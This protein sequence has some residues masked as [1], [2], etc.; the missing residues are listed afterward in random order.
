M[1]ITLIWITFRY[2]VS[3]DLMEKEDYEGGYI[4]NKGLGFGKKRF[5]IIPLIILALIIWFN[6]YLEYIIVTQI[7]FPI[8]YVLWLFLGTYIDAIDRWTVIFFFDDHVGYTHSTEISNEGA[9]LS[10]KNIMKYYRAFYE[11]IMKEK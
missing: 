5:F 2:L 3:Y 6:N 11:N 8:F 4:T 1:L 10:K 7:T 9:N